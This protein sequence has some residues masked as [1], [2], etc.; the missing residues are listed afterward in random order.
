MGENRPWPYTLSYT[1]GIREIRPKHRRGKGFE[2][3]CPSNFPYTPYKSL[4]L[5]VRLKCR[6]VVGLNG[7]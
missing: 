4:P 2:G 3:I 7:V 5:G 6:P 1:A